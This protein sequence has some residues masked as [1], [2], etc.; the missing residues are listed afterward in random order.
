MPE[1]GDMATAR[2]AVVMRDL[3]WDWLYRPVG[4][5]VDALATRLNLLQFLTIRRYLSLMF[6]AL[7]VLLIVVAVSQ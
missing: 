4:L 1:P 7:A 2:I 6:M 3:A 5:L